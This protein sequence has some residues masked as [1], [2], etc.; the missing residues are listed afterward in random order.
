VVVDEAAKVSEHS[1]GMG[2]EIPEAVGPALVLLRDPEARVD[3]GRPLLGRISSERLAE[4]ASEAGFRRILGAPGLAHRPEGA[5]DVSAGDAV[6]G[7]A[8]VVYEGTFVQPELM[9]LMVKHPL[10]PDERFTLYDGRGRPA[11]WFTGDLASVPA[12]MPLSEELDYPEGMGPEHIARVVYEEDVPA[13]EWLVLQQRGVVGDEQRSR[14]FTDVVVPTLRMLVRTPLT[15]AQI[16]LVALAVAI[17]AG[18]LALFDSW[19]A[20]VPAA[21]LL[22]AGVHTSRLLHAAARLR[23]EGG[24]P[25]QKPVGS[26]WR[27]GETL[28]HATRPL[29]HAVLAGT[30][31]YVLVSPPD[32]SQVAALVLLAAG[33]AGVFFSLAHARALLRGRTDS[34]LDLPDGWAFFAQI[35][36][37]LPTVLEGAPLLELAVFATALTGEP[38][39]PWLVLVAAALA[40]LWRWFTSPP[41]APE[42]VATD[43]T[44]GRGS[45]S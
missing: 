36:V 37:R 12:I 25:T 8:L 9:E 7:P 39:L 22:L 40:R 3:L 43:A 19:F 23:G 15:L 28:A 5:A 29:A 13:A 4:A 2:L 35:G 14:W 34:P 11:A 26:G 24:E 20:L 21:L 30:L 41:P 17:A 32:R 44:A 10:H 6:G 45:R 18:P 27:P 16:E 42:T 31:T 33:G 38:A 1:D